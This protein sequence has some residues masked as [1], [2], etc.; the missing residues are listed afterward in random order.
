MAFLG[1]ASSETT[2]QGD[3]RISP[4]SC[5]VGTRHSRE[6]VLTDGANTSR[7]RRPSNIALLIVGSSRYSDS[8][9]LSVRYHVILEIVARNFIRPRVP[10]V[11]AILEILR[12]LET[13]RINIITGRE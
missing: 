8:E 1:L 9:I 6:L 12:A 4:L 5:K 13:K 3:S 11:T 10:E 7:G 2:N